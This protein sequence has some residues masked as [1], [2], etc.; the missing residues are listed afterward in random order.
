LGGVQ[1][2]GPAA[3]R[4]GIGDAIWVFERGRRLF[5]GAVLLKAPPQC[6]TASQL[7]VVGVR[8]RKRWQEGEGLPAAGAPTATDPDP[9]V[10]LI[11]RLLAAASMANDRIAFTLGTSAQD[12]LVAAFGPIGFELVLR[13]RKWDKENRSSSGLCLG[14]DLPRSKPEAEPL[15]LKRKSQPEENN[16]SRLRILVVRLRGLAG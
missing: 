14:I 7:A 2:P 9:I 12:D 4:G 8:E 1:I 5:P 10:M 13:G 15:L 6:L 3:E 16:A 11:V